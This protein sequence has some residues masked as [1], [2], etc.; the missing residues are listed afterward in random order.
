[1]REPIRDKERI[2]HI[3]EAIDK[4]VET[5]IPILRDQIKQYLKEFD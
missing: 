2:A 1:M 3:D 5:D 4:L